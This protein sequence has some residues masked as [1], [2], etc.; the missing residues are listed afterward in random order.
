[1]NG[2]SWILTSVY[3]PCDSKGKIE[4][5]HW[6]ENIQMPHDVEWLIV[7]DF[8]LYRKPKDRNRPGANIADMFLFNSAIS[9]L[10]LVEIPLHG[11]RFT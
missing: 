2:E 1:M 9:A 5:M 3:G 6:F 7:G 8:N 11:R 4:F 10:G